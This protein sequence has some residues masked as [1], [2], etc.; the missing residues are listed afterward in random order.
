LKTATNGRGFGK[1]RCL[2]RVR[3]SDK[4]LDSQ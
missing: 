2:D 4:L 3:S 1:L